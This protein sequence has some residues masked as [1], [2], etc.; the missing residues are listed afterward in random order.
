MSA[1]QDLANANVQIAN[2]I[3]EV[4]RFRDAAMGINNLWPTITEGRNNTADG[5]YFSVPGGGAYM[6]LY[7]RNGSSQTLI[8][9]FP[10]RAQVQALVDTL[11]GRGVVGGSG[12]LMAVGAGGLLGELNSGGDLT[13]IDQTSLARF[14]IVASGKPRQGE[15]D[16]AGSIWTQRW[17]STQAL[18]LA[19]TFFPGNYR[20][21]MHIRGINPQEGTE[22]DPWVRLYSEN[23]I[24]GE[25]SQS[26]GVPTGAIFKRDSNSDGSYVL[27]A[28]GR[29]EI[30]KSFSLP[31]NQGNGARDNPHRTTPFTWEYPVP[32]LVNKE[33]VI[34]LSAT[35]GSTIAGSRNINVTAA[36]V[37]DTRAEY[38]QAYVMESA[39][40]AEQ[41]RISATIKGYWY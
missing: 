32:I 4:T 29:V 41:V 8:A 21:Q 34:I 31:F 23:N 17:S 40:P 35:L 14:G 13:L 2:L 30:T 22:T 15:A 38:I 27:S 33:R 36:N 28:D 20:N 11:G 25:V 5:K 9:E 6:R 19:H 12:D 3:G 7:R 10:D 1:E 24:L 18:Q 37:G 26:N 39:Q 16:T